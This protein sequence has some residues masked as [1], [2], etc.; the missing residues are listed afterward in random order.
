ME[1]SQFLCT[2]IEWNSV[3]LCSFGW[4]FPLKIDKHSDVEW[5]L[6][7]LDFCARIKKRENRDF[8]WNLFI[9]SSEIQ[10]WLCEMRCVEKLTLCKQNISD[11]SAFMIY[12]CTCRSLVDRLWPPPMES[13]R[14]GATFKREQPYKKWMSLSFAFLEK[15]TLC[16]H[17]QPKML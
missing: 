6:Q 11:M 12:V 10:N 14:V 7:S 15:K 3:V 17:E 2:N 4:Y 9:W 1:K 5:S 13:I 16:F 8:V